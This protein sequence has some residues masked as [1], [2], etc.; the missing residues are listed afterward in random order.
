MQRKRIRQEELFA[1]PS[2]SLGRERSVSR[3]RDSSQS[4]CG[5]SSARTDPFAY[6]SAHQR[7]RRI[8]ESNSDSRRK[9]FYDRRR[10]A[11]SS[12]DC[13]HDY[14]KDRERSGAAETT[15]TLGVVA[16]TLHRIAAVTPRKQ[17][18]ITRG[19][20]DKKGVQDPR[21]DTANPLHIR[22]GNDQATVS[23]L[24]KLMMIVQVYVRF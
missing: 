13:G 17:W 10:E 18:T 20:R 3:C 19:A 6:I 2:K 15:A 5:N 11:E 16:E 12:R 21:K 4:S 23:V 7:D 1:L 22:L 8:G 14:G 9:E 24:N